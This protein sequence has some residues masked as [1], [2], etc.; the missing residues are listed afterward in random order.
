MNTKTSI[1]SFNIIKK[2]W[3]F[4]VYIYDPGLA[5]FEVFD[6]H[7]PAKGIQRIS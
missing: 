4:F 6:L 1:L 3:P 5:D 7:F 2:P